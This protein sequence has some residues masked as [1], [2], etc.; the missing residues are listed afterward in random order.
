[1]ATWRPLVLI[2]GGIAELPVGSSVSGVF[3]NYTKIMKTSINIHHDGRVTVG[4]RYYLRGSVNNIELP[5]EEKTF[6]LT[7][8]Q[9]SVVLNSAPTPTA[10]RLIDLVDSFCEY[11]QNN[12]FVSEEDII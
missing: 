7:S 10:T 6:D 9:A 1:M 11:L 8:Q 4:L 2:D 3:D 12:G 5:I